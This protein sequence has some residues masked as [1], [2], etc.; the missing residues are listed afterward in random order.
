MCTAISFFRIDSYIITCKLQ[1]HVC[2]VCMCACLSVCVC[3]WC[4]RAWC[5]RACVCVCLHVHVLK[6]SHSLQAETLYFHLH[7]VLYSLRVKQPTT[8]QLPNLDIQSLLSQGMCYSHGL[9]IIIKILPLL[10]ICSLQS[11]HPDTHVLHTATQVLLVSKST[12]CS[13]DKLYM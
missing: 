2:V 5:V 7:V 4:V 9:Y 12:D 8:M 3:A 1:L 6:F 13:F 10:Y 11:N